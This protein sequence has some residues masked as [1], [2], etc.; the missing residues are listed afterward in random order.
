MSA[1]ARFSCTD[2][3]QGIRFRG[4][5]IPEVQ[6]AL[7]KPG[8]DREPYVEGMLWFL[9]T[10]E[11]PS[12]EQTKA[13]G[14][15][16]HARSRLPHYVESMIRTNR[17][18]TNGEMHPM[19]QFSSAVL[20]LQ[21]ESRFAH[22]YTMGAHKNEYWYVCVCVCVRMC[23]CDVPRTGCRSWRTCWTSL[24]DCLKWCP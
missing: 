21:T 23:A 2:T 19:T 7:P 5:T 11:V 12:E 13:L 4:K 22:S 8:P 17:S 15:E 16:L 6:A 14:E 10:G 9:L 20:G 24:R 18:F 1:V 3:P